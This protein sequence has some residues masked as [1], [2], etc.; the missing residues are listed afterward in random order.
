MIPRTYGHVGKPLRFK[1]SAYDYAFQRQR[2]PLAETTPVYG[3]AP[4]LRER[5]FSLGRS[6]VFRVAG[7]GEIPGFSA[8]FPNRLAHRG[9]SVPHG[10]RMPGPAF[11]HALCA[12][13]A[14][15]ARA[16]RKGGPSLQRRKHHGTHP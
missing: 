5:R 14:H 8:A 10:A 13:H 6:P 2:R 12:S 7:A 1:G 4:H 11:A 16:L 15:L 3:S 9:D